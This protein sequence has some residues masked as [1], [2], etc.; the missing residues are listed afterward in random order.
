MEVDKPIVTQG[1][2]N[3]ERT[4][5]S[6]EVGNKNMEAAELGNGA[7]GPR[8]EDPVRSSIDVEMADTSSPQ[9]S[10]KVTPKPVNLKN[11]KSYKWSK[12]GNGV[13]MAAKPIKKMPQYTEADEELG[14][15]SV[16]DT[17]KCQLCGY[18]GDDESPSAGRLLCSGLD[19]WVHINCGL[20][21]AEVFEDDDGKLQNVQTAITRGKQMVRTYL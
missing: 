18:Y 5:T 14:L 15:K 6:D 8:E 9:L 2:G 17:R 11:S 12:K 1:D 7:T 20:W 21:S 13:N 3:Q 16:L 19:E 4:S 10:S